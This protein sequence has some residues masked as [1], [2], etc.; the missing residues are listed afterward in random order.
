MILFLSLFFKSYSHKRTFFFSFLFKR[1]KHRCEREAL[2]G[3]L[4]YV[5]WPETEHVIRYVPWLEIEPSIFWLW[6][7]ASTNWA[8]LAKALSLLSC[9]RSAIISCKK[10]L[11]S[12]SVFTSIKWGFSIRYRWWWLN[13]LIQVPERIENSKILMFLFLAAKELHIFNGR[14][15]RTFLLLRLA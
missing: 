6:D 2:I 7:D 13:Y 14:E 1:E 12:E 4:S 5:P 10:I 9:S 8:T 15:F 3:C 11:G